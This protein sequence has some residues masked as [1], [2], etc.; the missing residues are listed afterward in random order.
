MI[1]K[2]LPSSSS[3]SV[4]SLHLLLLGFD[5]DNRVH[6]LKPEGRLP[7]GCRGCTSGSVHVGIGTRAQ[8]QL[9]AAPPRSRGQ[10]VP[11]SKGEVLEADAAVAIVIEVGKDNIGVVAS[12][13]KTG[14]EITKFFEVYITLPL[15]VTTVE[16]LLQPHFGF[17]FACGH[18]RPT[19]SQITKYASHSTYCH[20]R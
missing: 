16:K 14:A 13:F 18:K 3:F 5:L 19:A 2:V 20:Y 12:D 7:D 1:G 8:S 17:A 10:E 6:F 4:L 15:G 11:E 9:N